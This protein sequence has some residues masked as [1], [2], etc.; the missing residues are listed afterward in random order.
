MILAKAHHSIPEAG[1]Y[2]YLDDKPI[3]VQK[4]FADKHTLP[5]SPTPG[6]HTL[7]V[8]DSWG[9]RSSVGFEVIE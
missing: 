6:A 1:L 4:A 3:S 2:W 5:V 8:I 7:T 9:N